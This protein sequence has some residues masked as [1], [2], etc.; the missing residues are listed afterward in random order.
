MYQLEISVFIRITSYNVCY[1]KLLRP[2]AGGEGAK[3]R[4]A[5]IAQKRLGKERAGGI[6]RADEDH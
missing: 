3:P 2:C 4:P 1:T 6:A 5:Q